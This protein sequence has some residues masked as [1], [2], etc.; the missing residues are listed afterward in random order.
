MGS[1]AM[2]VA[3]WVFM[4]GS[5]SAVLTLAIWC[6]RKVLGLPPDDNK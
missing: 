5:V 2:T 1:A 6:Y 4:I 3:G